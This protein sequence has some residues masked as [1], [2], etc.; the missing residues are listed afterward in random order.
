MHVADGADGVFATEAFAF[1]VHH[2]KD[3]TACEVLVVAEG[4]D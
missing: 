1:Q 2:A 4:V 3:A